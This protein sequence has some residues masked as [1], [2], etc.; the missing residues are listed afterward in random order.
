[1]GW[2]ERVYPLE[3][4]LAAKQKALNNAGLNT[5]IYFLK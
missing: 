4:G 2:D 3:L 1:M 5:R